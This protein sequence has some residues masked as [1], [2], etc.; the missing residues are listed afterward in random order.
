MSAFENLKA[1]S[2]RFAGTDV[3]AA[4]VK[5][6]IDELE[7]LRKM[8]DAKPPMTF[9]EWKQEPLLRVMPTEK[10]FPIQDGP[11]VP[12][13]AMEPHERQAQRNHSGQTLA[14]LAERHGLSCAEAWWVINDTHYQY[15]QEQRATAQFRAWAEKIN[16]R[17]ARLAEKEAEI[18]KARE[19]LKSYVEQTESLIAEKEGEIER[20]QITCDAHIAHIESLEWAEKQ[21]ASYEAVVEIGKRW[22]QAIAA[23]HAKT[24]IGPGPHPEREAFT[25]LEESLRAALAGLEKKP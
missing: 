18:V 17:E 14:R 15:G 19:G 8:R 25:A 7:A 11:S 6:L 20:W 16:E 2:E 22:A 12:W 24:F 23:I 1:W 4:E 21:L 10:R 9:E 3:I 5:E 13:W